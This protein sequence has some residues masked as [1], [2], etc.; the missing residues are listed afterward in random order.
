MNNRINTIL[1]VAGGVLLALAV[2]L[3]SHALPGYLDQ[4]RLRGKEGQ[5]F[6]IPLRRP[7]S[8]ERRV[9]APDLALYTRAGEATQLAGELGGKATVLFFWTSWSE[10]CLEALPAYQALYEAL[11]QDVRLVTVN[12]TDSGPETLDAAERVLDGGGYTFPAFFDRDNAA[13]T[14]YSLRGVPA[15]VFI[16]KNGGIAGALEGVLTLEALEEGVALAQK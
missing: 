4:Q 12:L 6:A 10:P 15:T 2:T 16:D 3:L 8:G 5:P 14:L 13:T 7:S 11:P 1:L 9:E